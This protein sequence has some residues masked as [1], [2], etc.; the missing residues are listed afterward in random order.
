M[1]DKAPKN[2]WLIAGET[3]G[4][5]YGARLATELK[6]LAAKEG[7]DLHISGMGG[8]KMRDAGVDI[9]VDS[10]ELDVIGIL[11]VFKHIFTFIRIF[12]YLVNKA[13]TERPDA[14]VLIDY[15]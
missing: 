7:R 4:E 9:L 15:P 11:E 1:N 13:K 6:D 3:S 8:I 14:V 12:K 2:I 10:S 5:M